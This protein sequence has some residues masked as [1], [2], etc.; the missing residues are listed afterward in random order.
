MPSIGTP[1]VQT[2]DIAQIR[3]NLPTL[4]LDGIAASPVL[5]HLKVEVG[6]RPAKSG[7]DRKRKQARQE[8]TAKVTVQAATVELQGPERPGGRPAPVKVNVVLVK[9]QS[10]PVGEPA[11]EWLLVTDL[12]VDSAGANV[13]TLA[14]QLWSAKIRD[15]RLLEGATA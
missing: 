5:H 15:E 13:H 14:P 6:K 3:Y 11:L 9:E 4:S 7:D 10:P 8:R 1:C 12:A 2:P